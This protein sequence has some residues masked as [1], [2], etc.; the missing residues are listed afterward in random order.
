M[1]FPFMMDGFI[2]CQAVVLSFWHM[3]DG[4]IEDLNCLQVFILNEKNIIKELDCAVKSSE[5]QR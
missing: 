1:T 4:I 2:L 3:I 5:L